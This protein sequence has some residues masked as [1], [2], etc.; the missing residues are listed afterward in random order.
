MQV[1]G[2]LHPVIGMPGQETTN[3]S[4]LKQLAMAWARKQGMSIRE[5]HQPA[6]RPFLLPKTIACRLPVTAMKTIGKSKSVT[7]DVSQSITLR[8]VFTSEKG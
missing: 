3:H 7:D 2:S 4:N 8:V 1:Q 6:V 5:A